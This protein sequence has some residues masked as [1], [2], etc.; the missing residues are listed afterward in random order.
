VDDA[1]G[2]D[3][4]YAVPEKSVCTKGFAEI[5]YR[6]LGYVLVNALQ[7]VLLSSRFDR[8]HRR[9]W[10]GRVSQVLIRSDPSGPVLSRKL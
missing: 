8:S 10:K 5:D 3:L 4:N 1:F 9:P 7:R 2:I 6:I